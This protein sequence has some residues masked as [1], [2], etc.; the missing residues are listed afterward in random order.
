[1]KLKSTLGFLVLAGAICLP[2]VS[3]AQGRRQDART[4]QFERRPEEKDTSAGGN[5]ASAGWDRYREIAEL[6]I[7][8]RDRKPRP[9]ASGFPGFERPP[10]IETR[11]R[12]GAGSD[13]PGRN[14]VLIGVS[15]VGSK[16]FAFFENI[17]EK[18]LV[19]AAIGDTVGGRKITAITLDK[20]QYDAGGKPFDVPLRTT[21]TGEKAAAVSAEPPPSFGG[22]FG[23]RF[24]R[25]GQRGERGDRGERGEGGPPSEAAPSSNGEKEKGKEEAKSQ[26]TS[27]ENVDDILERLR[28]RREEEGAR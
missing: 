27:T 5:S 15:K 23:G 3:L 9:R 21:L 25:P 12:P 18:T 14:F 8:S 22:P 6:N 26:S 7:F 20:V 11:P 1:M 4:R 10:E 17:R 24:S 16:Q 28:K 13:D 19:P 2:A